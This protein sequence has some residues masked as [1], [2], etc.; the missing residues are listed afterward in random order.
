MNKDFFKDVFEGRKDLLKR[1]DVAFIEVKEYDELSVKA[2]FP[3]F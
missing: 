3:M 1:K 2:M